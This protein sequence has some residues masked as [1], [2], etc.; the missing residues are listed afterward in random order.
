MKKLPKIQIHKKTLSWS[1]I[2][3]EYLREEENNPRQEKDYVQFFDRLTNRQKKVLNLALKEPLKNEVKPYIADIYNPNTNWSA[4]NARGSIS[5]NVRILNSFFI[6]KK[7]GKEILQMRVRKVLTEFLLYALRSKGR[8]TSSKYLKRT[9]MLDKK[10]TASW[11]SKTDYS[12]F[13][14]KIQWR[15]KRSNSQ[16]KLRPHNFDFSQIKPKRETNIADKNKI[17]LLQAFDAELVKLSFFQIYL[18]THQTRL[19][20]QQ[21]RKSFDFS[22]FSCTNSTPKSAKVTRMKHYPKACSTI[23]Y[24]KEVVTRL[25][26]Q[27]FLKNHPDQVFIKSWFMNPNKE[28]LDEKFYCFHKLTFYTT[29]SYCRTP[30]EGAEAIQ[31]VNTSDYIKV[32]RSKYTKLCELTAKE[33]LTKIKLSSLLTDFWKNKAKKSNIRRKTYFRSKNNKNVYKFFEAVYIAAM[34]LIEEFNT[35]N[36]EDPDFKENWRQGNHSPVQIGNYLKQRKILELKNQEKVELER[37]KRMVFQVINID[38]GLRYKNTF[39]STEMINYLK[40]EIV[41]FVEAKN[42]LLNSSKFMANMKQNLGNLKFLKN[43]KKNNI[44]SKK[45]TMK[46]KGA[47]SA[48]R[49]GNSFSPKKNPLRKKHSINKIQL[50]HKSLLQSLDDDSCKEKLEEK[51]KKSHISSVYKI[52]GSQFDI[53]GRISISKFDLNRASRSLGKK[54]QHKNTK[55]AFLLKTQDHSTSRNPSASKRSSSKKLSHLNSQLIQNSNNKSRILKSFHS[56]TS[57]LQ[58]PNTFGSR[59]EVIKGSQKAY[60]IEPYTRKDKFWKKRGNKLPI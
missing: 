20:T 44:W 26:H 10:W 24:L 47:F 8:L 1:G 9:K 21:R 58:G 2:A 39:F 11:V 56:R 54:K 45:N 41:V 13:K 46:M 51:M 43:R 17:T 18:E 25:E 34:I 32:L 57:S 4:R 53:K 48:S 38:P 15:P 50:L 60:L 14:P 33:R 36:H 16:E 19:E 52:P 40:T 3:E 27:S 5:L 59:L 49:L 22:D 29:T 37:V 31:V 23:P 12:A 55:S 42:I 30:E 35:G 28:E 7:E 6:L